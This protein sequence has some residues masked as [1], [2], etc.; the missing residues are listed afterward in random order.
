[1]GLI[2][3]VSWLR[4]REFGP[5]RESSAS[6]SGERGADIDLGLS[7]GQPP[8]IRGLL[9]EAPLTVIPGK[10]TAAPERRAES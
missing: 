5:V 6:S 4:G 7:E 10:T 2:P 3:H 1:M 9:G 8:T